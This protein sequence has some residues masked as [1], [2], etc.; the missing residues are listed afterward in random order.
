[1]KKKPNLLIIGN[2]NV[3]KSSIARLLLTNPKKYKGKAGKQPGSTL[4][5]KTVDLP[6]ILI[7]YHMKILAPRIQMQ[8]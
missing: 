8:I 4:L 3:G 7:F 1:M 6:Q 5:I 2:S